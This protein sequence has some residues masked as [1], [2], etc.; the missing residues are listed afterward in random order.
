MT[1]RFLTWQ[2]KNGR[3]KNHGKT[4]AK[5]FYDIIKRNENSLINGKPN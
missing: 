4:F 1:P 3:L 2:V 5:L